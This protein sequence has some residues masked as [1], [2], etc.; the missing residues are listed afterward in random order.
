MGRNLVSFMPP[1]PVPLPLVV[2]GLGNPP[3]NPLEDQIPRR[4]FRHCVRTPWGPAT[5]PETC[6]E[7][8]RCARPLGT[9]ELTEASDE[10]GV[11]F[12]PAGRPVKGDGLARSVRP[13]D[14]TPRV[15]GKPA[16]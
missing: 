9:A 5:L 14:R 12:A 11:D 6:R 8:P 4:P 13:R 15:W 1:G 16:E 7:P 3:K 10:T 2:L